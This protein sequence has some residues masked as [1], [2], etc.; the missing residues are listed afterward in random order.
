MVTKILL[1]MTG[2]GRT[3]KNIIIMGEEEEEEEEEEPTTT[4]TEASSP[5]REEG[6]GGGSSSEAFA[7]K[8]LVDSRNAGAVLG[9]FGVVSS[10]FARVF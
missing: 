10:S 4:T 6:G 5:T 9:V 1:V 7:L 3:K 2:R 8:M